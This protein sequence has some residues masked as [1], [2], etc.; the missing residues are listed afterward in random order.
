MNTRR[1]DDKMRLGAFFMPTGHHVASWR[2]PD[3][4]PDAGVNFQHYAKLAQAAEQAKFDMIFL[5][6]NYAVRDTHPEALRRSAQYIAN[7]EPLTLLSGLAALTKHIGLIAT[8]STSYNEPFHVARNFSSLD[9]ISSGRAG[10]NMVTSAQE[11]E[12]HNFGR[13]KHYGHAERYV[14]AAEF[15]RVAIG[16]WDSWEDDAFIRDK[17]SGHFLDPDKLHP[18]HHKGPWFTVRG[19][20]NIPRSPQGWPVLVQAGSSEDGQRFAAEF[21]EVIFSGHLSIDLALTYYNAVK[22]RVTEFGRSPS[23]I[24]IMPGLNP[25][26]GRTAE[27]AKEKLELLNSL[28]EPVVAREILSTFLRRDISVYDFEGPFPDLQPDAQSSGSFYNWVELAKREKLTIRQTAFRAA[29]GRM[30]VITGSAEQIA[31]H[32]E[33]WFLGGACDGFNIMPPYLPGAFNDF[34]ELVV[35]ELQRRGLFRTEY[36]GKTL[37][38][39]LGLRRPASRYALKETAAT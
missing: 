19:P 22:K 8:A 16:L 14:R 13:E 12:A 11:A 10:W 32:M 30:S 37:R 15:T 29:R 24:K 25:I 18:I 7:F 36:E 35:P 9:H 39:N 20:M 28:I 21:A 23:D 1:R 3:A 5:G 6:D 2:H 33:K 31:D 26:V 38:E 17:A 34:V 4:D 27:E